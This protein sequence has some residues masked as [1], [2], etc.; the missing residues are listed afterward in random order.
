M[1]PASVVSMQICRIVIAKAKPEA[2]Q[3]KLMLDCFATLAMT[4]I[5]S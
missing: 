3:K 2:I 5:Y 1:L 4:I